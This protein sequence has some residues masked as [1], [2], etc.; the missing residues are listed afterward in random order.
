MINSVFEQ[1]QFHFGLG[2]VYSVVYFF[3]FLVSRYIDNISLINDWNVFCCYVGWLYFFSEMDIRVDPIV[4]FFLHICS[5]DA[6]CRD[7]F[8]SIFSWMYGIPVIFFD[9]LDV[10]DVGGGAV[11]LRGMCYFVFSFFLF[12]LWV[13]MNW[14]SF[15]LFFIFFLVVVFFLKPFL[16]LGEQRFLFNF[17][18]LLIKKVYVF[19]YDLVYSYLK[20]DTRF[21][22]PFIFF[23]FL[24]ISILNLTGMIPYSFALTSHLIV[25][26][27][28][29]VIS[30]GG[31]V[32]YGM[33]KHGFKFFT[34]F[35]PK[36]LSFYLVP[37][38][39]LI[40]LVSH[41][42]RLISLSL[43]LFSNIVAGHILLD[44]VSVFLYKMT[45]SN[46][47]SFKLLLLPL[48]FLIISVL[49][50]FEL[51]ICILQGYIFAV[52]SCI[53]CKDYLYLL[54]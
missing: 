2:D 37:F 42:T 18:L 50:F 27:S 6:C 9:S 11:L 10:I 4:F 5:L 44:L 47:F 38:L 43:R 20:E 3:V 35:Y 8:Y 46:I 52:L 39:C 26:F 33:E 32:L 28:L 15:M 13:V 51:A 14:G 31:F 7:L 17:M 36:G 12:F 24:F 29:S 21:F 16:F 48:G 19:F 49:F 1:F 30:W 22:F 34:L 53:Y 25:T 45:L 54:H 40:E 23:I 41:F